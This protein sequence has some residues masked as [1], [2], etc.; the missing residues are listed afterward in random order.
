MQDDFEAQQRARER[1]F[2]EQ[3]VIPWHGLCQDDYEFGEWARDDLRD[4]G[5]LYEYSRESHRFRC[6]LALDKRPAA[7]HRS[8]PLRKFEG[9][10]GYYIYL[11]QSGWVRWLQSFADE[12]I[13]NMSFAELLRTNRSKVQKSLDELPNYSLLSNAVELPGRYTNYPQSQVVE[14]Q[15]FFGR[16]TNAE[17]G[18]EMKSL[19]AKLRP[20]DWK[21]PDRKG[22]GKAT[23]VVALLDGLSAM[24][25]ASHYPK[26]LP[27]E[28][29]RKKRRR[30][31][32]GS[33]TAV[34]I[35]NKIRLGGKTD[36]V[37]THSDLEEYSGN[38]RRQFARWFPFGE[39]P[40]NGITWAKRRLKK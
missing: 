24:R 26:T 11:L 23:S 6:D 20:D 21:E 25:L 29:I 14:I 8:L 34:S 35:F 40:A 18:E 22:R 12:L 37:L 7:S 31:W 19:A 15:I 28:L 16:F 1:A 13:A 32:R 17:I 27:S 30:R 10:S 5:C 36:T 4:A 33:D 39:T 38:A 2:A 3:D 9:N